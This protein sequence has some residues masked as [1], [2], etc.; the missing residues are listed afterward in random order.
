MYAFTRK[1]QCEEIAIAIEIKKHGF[2]WKNGDTKSK[3]GTGSSNRRD[4]KYCY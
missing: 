2:D 3:W 4:K 1:L